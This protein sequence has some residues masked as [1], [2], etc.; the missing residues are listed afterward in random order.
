MSHMELLI[1]ISLWYFKEVSEGL[2]G[3]IF[4]WQIWEHLYF[5]L[6]KCEPPLLISCFPAVSEYFFPIPA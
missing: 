5:S 2:Q 1:L 4:S 6:S 3:S